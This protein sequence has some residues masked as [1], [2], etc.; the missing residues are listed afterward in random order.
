MSLELIIGSMY[1]GKSTELMRRIKRVKSIGMRCLVINHSN[2]TRVDGDFV[3]THDGSTL[4]AVKTKDLLLVNIKPYDTIAID[5]AQFFHNLRTAVMLMVETHKKHVIVALLQDGMMLE[6]ASD[7]LKND[8]DVVQ[9]AIAQNSAAEQF[10]SD[11]MKKKLATT[12]KFSENVIKL[13]KRVAP[14]VTSF[15]W[16][17]IM[18]AFAIV[19]FAFVYFFQYEIMDVDVDGDVDITDVVLLMDADR[20]GVVEVEERLVVS[21]LAGFGLTGLLLSV[22]MVASESFK[23]SSSRCA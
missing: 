14:C 9:L 19:C 18:V 3:Q 7:A 16:I 23:R 8:R 20:D 2:D 17:S 10:V 13:N 12:K 21:T 4:A 11:A 22:Q 6:F 5:E 15:K 1:S